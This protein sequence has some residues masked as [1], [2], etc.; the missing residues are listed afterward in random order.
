[1]SLPVK[2]TDAVEVVKSLLEHTMPNCFSYQ[3][4]LSSG[5]NMYAG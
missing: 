1:V 3:M 5:G 4:K 2:P